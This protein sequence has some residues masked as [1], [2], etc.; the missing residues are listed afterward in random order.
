MNRPAAI[1]L[2][3]VA[4]AL[5]LLAGGAG[6]AAAFD[7]GQPLRVIKYILGKKPS[8]PDGAPSRATVHDLKRPLPAPGTAAAGKKPAAPAAP[9]AGP[10]A[11]GTAPAEAVPPADGESGTN[12]VLDDV[13]LTPEPYYYQTLGRRDPFQSLVGEEYMADHPG[14]DLQP[15]EIF[16]RGIL[17]GDRDRFALVETASGTNTIVR[18]GDRIGPYSVTQIDRDA[19][20]VYTSLY[21]IGKT[22]RIPMAEGK[23][24]KNGRG[25]R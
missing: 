24:N 9:Q 4:L 6:R 8:G 5:C 20:V 21:G 16:V 22:V 1:R 3:A 12:D 13:L 15:E 11:A 7:F 25:Q 14:E 19:I 10:V 23:G 17:W 18:Q 2:G